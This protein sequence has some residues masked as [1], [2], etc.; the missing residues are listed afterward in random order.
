MIEEKNLLETAYRYAREIEHS[1]INLLRLEKLFDR[2]PL[3][4]PKQLIRILSV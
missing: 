2:L 4:Q 1:D 3:F